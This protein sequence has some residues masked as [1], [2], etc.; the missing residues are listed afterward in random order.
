[1]AAITKPAE[2]MEGNRARQSV[3]G[4]AL[5][6]HVGRVRAQALVL[7]PIQIMDSALD[8]TDLPHGE[9]GKFYL[10]R[11]YGET[12]HEMWDVTDPAHPQP[13]SDIP[14]GVAV[15][16]VAFS[17]DGRTLASASNTEIQLWNIAADPIT[18]PPLGKP[19][20]G[21]AGAVYWVTFSSDGHTLASGDNDGTI[22]LWNVADPRHPRL[23]GQPLSAG[24]G[25][26]YSVAFS[27][28]NHMLASGN[29]D[30]SIALWNVADLAHPRLLGQPL[31][32]GSQAVYAVAFGP[33]GRT[34]ASGSIDGAVR[35]WN[36]N[37]DYATERICAT[38]GQLTHQQWQAYIS[39]LPYQALCAHK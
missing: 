10:L 30:G 9:R 29:D 39:Q 24:T 7:D 1:V 5:V 3:P 11:S 4:F 2:L 18:P 26:V 25:T 28:D 14:N 38:A 31:T 34:L 36:L 37:V 32:S 16:S 8:A 23:P 35:L 22:R 19:L 13:L 15:A 27:P 12:S 6:Q 20:T 17:P 33:G 21:G